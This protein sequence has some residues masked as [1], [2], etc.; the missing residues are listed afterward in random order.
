[1][2]LT[3]G[4][5]IPGI[6]YLTGTKETPEKSSKSW[7]KRFISSPYTLVI[8]GLAT[9]ALVAYIIFKI[10]SNHKETMLALGDIIKSIPSIK[11]K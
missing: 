1:M 2:M 9:L 3:H 8:I 11:L 4:Y 10:T 5:A 7:F 6:Q